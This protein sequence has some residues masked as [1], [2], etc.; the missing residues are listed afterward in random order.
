MDSSSIT[1]HSNSYETV[2]ERVIALVQELPPTA[3]YS[4]VIEEIYVLEKL[5]IARKELD[6]GQIFTQEQVKE[7]ARS[8]FE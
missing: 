4:Q 8:W 3:T 6:A 1:S 7:M 5:E 2:K